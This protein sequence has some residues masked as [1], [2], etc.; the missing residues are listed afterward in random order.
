MKYKINNLSFYQL[1]DKIK[2]YSTFRI[3]ISSYKGWLKLYSGTSTIYFKSA[4]LR[5]EFKC[6]INKKS[7]KLKIIIIKK[8]LLISNKDKKIIP[9]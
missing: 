5:F 7:K 4:H 9:R 1:N 6:N 8:K 3:N 2:Y